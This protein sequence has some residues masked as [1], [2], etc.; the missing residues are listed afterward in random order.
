MACI[1]SRRNTKGVYIRYRDWRLF[2][3]PEDG[4]NNDDN[5]FTY[6]PSNNDNG[7]NGDESDKNESDNYNNTNLNP[8]PDQ[9]MAQ[10]PTGVTIHN[11]TVVHQNENSGVHQTTK[12]AGVNQNMNMHSP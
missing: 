2:L 11:N 1:V 10:G 4:S 9:K 7:N 12:N 8:P 6:A 3:E 5:D